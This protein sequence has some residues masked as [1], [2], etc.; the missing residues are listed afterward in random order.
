MIYEPREDSYLLAGVIPRYVLSKRVLDVGTGSGIQ[1]K[2]AKEAGAASVTATDINPK[3]VA[4]LRAKGIKT[5]KSNLFENISGIFDVII[6]NPP[7]LPRDPREDRESQE[8][9]TGGKRGDEF[10]VRF[11]KQASK[12][13]AQ[14]GCILLLL[15]SLTP[16][17]RIRKTLAEYKL[18]SRMLVRK[19]LFM[20]ELRVLKITRR[21]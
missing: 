10:I 16:R 7:Y 2:V 3:A 6:C 8:A 9:T 17:D 18:K 13:L 12:H 5:I 15:S 20:E 21:I 1:A 4:A 11:I 19:K 14:R